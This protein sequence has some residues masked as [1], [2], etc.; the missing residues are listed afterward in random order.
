MDPRNRNRRPQLLYTA[1]VIG[2]AALACLLA[3]AR[4]NGEALPLGTALAAAL[5]PVCGPAVLAGSIFTFALTG[6]LTQSSGTVCALVL[7]VLLRWLLGDRCTPRPAALAAGGSTLLSALAFSL[8]GLV[9][10]GDWPVV[11]AGAAVSAGAAYCAAYVAGQ[12]RQGV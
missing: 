1:G 4:Y 7:T 12:L 8:G 5:P 2:C 6:T 10:G 9:R 3:S 11:L